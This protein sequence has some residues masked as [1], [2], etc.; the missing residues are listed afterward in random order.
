MYCSHTVRL[1]G[2]NGNDHTIVPRQGNDCD[3]VATGETEG[4]VR[5]ML[6]VQAA[7]AHAELSQTL[8]PERARELDAQMKA[9]MKREAE[10]D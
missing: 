10:Q 9:M 3:Y 2:D 6:H 7:R 8:S 4:L 1:E 5:E